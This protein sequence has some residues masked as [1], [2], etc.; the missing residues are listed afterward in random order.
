M[1]KLE[2]I[3]YRIAKIVAESDS[4]SEGYSYCPK[5]TKRMYKKEI[6]ESG[7]THANIAKKILKIPVK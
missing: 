5:Y 4:I 2:L 1:E 6:K 3:R 7:D